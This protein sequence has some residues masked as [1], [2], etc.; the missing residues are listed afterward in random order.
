MTDVAVLVPRRPDGGH[1]DRL[2]AFARQRMETDFPDFTIVEGRD[3]G[4]GPFNRSAA[5][6]D[7][8]R[9]AGAW[10]VA[11]IVDSDILANRRAVL[12]AVEIAGRTDAF[13]VSHN[14]RVMLTQAGTTK[15]MDGYTGSWRTKQMHDKVWTDSVSCCVIVSRGL[16]DLVGGFDELF[17][18]WGYE[19]TAFQIACETLTDRPTVVLQSELFHLWHARGERDQA[20]LEANSVRVNRY[21][22]AQWNPSAVEQLLYEWRSAAMTGTRI[23]RIFHRTVPEQTT[24]EVEQWWA[25]L[26][27]I[28]PGFLFRTYREPVD[29]ADFPLTSDLWGRCENGAQKAGLIRLEALHAWGGVYVD[30]DVRPVRSF[31]PLLEVAAFAAW[32]DESTVPDAVLGSQ[33]KHPAFEEMLAKARASITGGGNAWQSGP[34]VTTEVLPNRDDVLLLP[35]GSFY[36][37]HYLRKAEAGAHNDD[38]WVICEHMW[39]HSWGSAASKAS[40]EKR[41][42]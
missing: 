35:P 16:F 5:I 27:R 8:A 24:D 36:P 11:V 2:W 41:Q 17:V 20:L 30:S 6:N 9:Q 4:D 38:P 10:D 37:H 21:R 42:R 12:A 19:D 28:H 39:H 26:Q 22:D 18:G 1:R 40:I 31:T 14:E 34:G 7:A 13:V 32:E 33:P 25:D 23:P 29:P 15:V 3:Q